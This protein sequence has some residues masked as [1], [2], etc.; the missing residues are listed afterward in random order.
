MRRLLS[1]IILLLLVATSAFAQKVHD[2][3]TIYCKPGF[4][5][6]LNVKGLISGTSYAGDGSGLTNITVSSIS[7]TTVSVTNISATVADIRTLRSGQVST[8][9]L[10]A[11]VADITTLRA[12]TLSGNGAGLSGVIA[13]AVAWPNV[14]GVPS[15]LVAVSNGTPI[16]LTGLTVAGTI[17]GASLIS[18]SM[19]G[20]ISGTY[21]YA[22]YISGTQ[23]ALGSLTVNGVSITGAA[24]DWY[25]LT[26]I[27]AQV[28]AVSNGT[29]ITMAGISATTV[30]A[31][32]V[33][34]TAPT[35][36]VSAT[37]GYFKFVS[38]T[39]AGNGAGITGVTANS[40][41][42]YNI[43]RVP[44]VLQN[45][46]NSTGSVTVTSVAANLVSATTIS[47]TYGY[48]QYVSGTN[49]LATQV[50]TSGLSSTLADIVTIRG[51]GAG[52]TGVSAA[53][54]DYSNIQN[55]PAGVVNIGAATGSVTI[56]TI[57]AALASA[58]TTSG[59]YGY[60]KFVSGTF[61]GDGTGLTNVSASSVGY[62]NVQNKPAGVVNIGLGSG[63]VTATSVE[64]TTVSA[65]GAAG[66]VTATFGYFGKVSATSIFAPTI[67]ATNLYGGSISGTTGT[68]GGLLV[69]NGISS[70]AGISATGDIQTGGF[71]RG[72]G[73]KLINLPGGGS[74]GGNV[75]DIQYKLT[76]TAFGADDNYQYLSTTAVVSLTGTFNTV[77]VTAIN[78]ILP[79]GFTN[80]L[81]YT[82][83]TTYTW[84]PSATQIVQYEIWGPGGGGGGTVNGSSSAGG[85]GGAYC[86]G[87]T[88]VTKNVTLTI[89]VGTGGT[90]GT[91]AGTTGAAGSASSTITGGSL[92]V[93]A[94]YGFGGQGATAINVAEV[95][96]AGG[97]YSGCKFGING[98]TGE[99]AGTPS[100]GSPLLAGSGGGSPR[101]GLGG[102]RGSIGASATTN[103]QNGNPPGG[104]GSGSP[105]TGS[106]KPG[107]NGSNGG[108]VLNCSIC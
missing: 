15:P 94:G 106:G 11:T 59:T 74:P 29:N 14:N 44:T 30:T 81:V 71:F 84:V 76:S 99:G 67:S 17:S 38:G 64:A 68:F 78:S 86:T 47:G 104:A 93:V 105:G 73:S 49:L 95:G 41:D 1:C 92:A 35:G 16:S 77:T 40:V 2:C 3:D 65:T 10:S 8:T 9:N 50:S 103:W 91:A 37:Y 32:N 69:A 45:I 88:S 102:L 75:N 18:T 87:T 107:G 5:L 98:E 28:T 33:F 58:T 19:G 20:I 51:G 63:S 4:F 80:M 101:G 7:L 25:T 83:P 39:L 60:F 26:N 62:A 36:T 48:F 97:T 90:G 34:A 54:V 79:Q 13:A 66:T 85:G 27:P 55:K 22:K 23:A 6:G 56:T 72:D 100:G 46:S 52:I 61:A 70:T 42:W 108:A 82:T 12:G 24:P 53:S 43:L 96:G 21:V 57:A 89:V 31:T